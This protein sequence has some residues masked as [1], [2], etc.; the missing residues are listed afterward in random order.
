MKKIKLIVTDMDGCLLDGKGNLPSGFEETFR[1]MEEKGVVFAAASGRSVAGLKKPFGEL[2]SR[3]AF[4]TDNGGGVYEKDRQLFSDTIEKK[5]LL[6]IFEAARKQ[7]DLVTVAC[8]TSDAWIEHADR[9]TQKEIAELS[10]YYPTWKEC[11]YE[12]IPE[13]IIKIALLYFDDIEKN[14]Y[15]V[16]AKFNNDRI[17]AKVTAFVWIDI[18]AADV[19]KGRGVAVLQEKLGIQKEETIVFGD[20][21]NDL[22]MADFAIRSF[23]PSNAHSAV[24]ERF[25]DV[26]GSNEDGAVLKTITQLLLEEHGER[27]H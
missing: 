22:S 20:Y 9:L 1:L 17:S 27:K 12:E 23:A 11:R 2:A 24:K 14:I 25:T 15:P 3:M 13:D 4:V 5:D 21:L 26:I 7:K 6:P 16:F 10:K 19:S 18:C 8:G